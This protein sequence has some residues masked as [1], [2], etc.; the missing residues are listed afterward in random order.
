[1][2]KLDNESKVLLVSNDTWLA[3]RCPACIV[4]VLRRVNSIQTAA[5]ACPI[6]TT[7]VPGRCE[8][9]GRFPL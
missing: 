9:A 4:G 2:K 7:R 8:S 6:Q 5:V 1:M 3:V